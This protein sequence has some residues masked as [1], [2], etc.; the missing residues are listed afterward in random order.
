MRRV[1]WFG[2]LIGVAL[3]AGPARASTW[4]VLES[5]K[6]SAEAADRTGIW[7]E[8]ERM[9]VDIAGGRTSVVYDVPAGMIWALDHERKTV[10]TLD[11][12]TATSAATRLHK[13]EA[14]LRARTEGLPPEARAAATGLIDSAFGPEVAAIPTLELR[15]TQERGRVRGIACSVREIW[16]DGSR[17]VRFCEATL[18]DAGISPGAMEPLRSLSGFVRD[19]APLLP[20][21]LLSG[22]L[23]ALDLFD[24]I[25]GVPLRIETF[26]GDAVDRI[27]VVS[28]IVEAVPPD[29]TFAVPD[30][31]RP[32]L[33]IKVRERLGG[34]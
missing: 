16:I 8:A 21:R 9:R 22:G 6:A 7:A 31:Y 12:S 26:T 23:A 3:A 27:A 30:D 29:G 24:R 2:V 34:P 1:A 14:E 19:I 13:V 11:R 20:E 32:E 10:L 15:D 17:E 4:L 18:G 33:A 28:E 5:R 25:E